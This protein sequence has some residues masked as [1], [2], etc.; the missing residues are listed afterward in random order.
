[1]KYQTSKDSYN[2]PEG[3]NNYL[4]FLGSEDGQYFQKVLY[5]AF[6]RRVGEDKN[7]NILDAACGPGWLTAKLAT[8]FSNIIGV[9][10]SGPFLDH[11]KLTYPDLKFTAADLNKPLDYQDNYFDTIIMSMAAHDIENQ[12]QTFTEFK[13]ILKPG[14]KLLLTFVNPYYAFPVG[15]WKR[16]ILGRILFKKPKLKL[17]P[18]F[19]YKNEIRNFTFYDN[20]ECYFY[21]LPEHLNHL[22]ESGFK[23][24][25]LEDLQSLEDSENYNLQYRLHR[26]PIILFIECIKPAI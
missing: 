25:F 19:E 8:E 13:R 24:N 10:A 11:A 21:T 17:R 12:V 18:Y 5:Q 26:F 1:M 15:V 7:Q 3:A 9:D 20:L 23:F 2:A 16:G 4:K 14:G 22:N 6:R